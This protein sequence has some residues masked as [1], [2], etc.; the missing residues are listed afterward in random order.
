M[1]LVLINLIKGEYHEK[2]K[3]LMI[4]INKKLLLSKIQMIEFVSYTLKLND[5]SD[6]AKVYE[7]MYNCDFN[8]KNYKSCFGGIRNFEQLIIAEELVN[9]IYAQQNLAGGDLLSLQAIMEYFAC[10]KIIIITNV[11]K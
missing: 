8:G 2:I 10:K 6:F 4:L 5:K 11:F 9:E 7:A 3:A 1:K